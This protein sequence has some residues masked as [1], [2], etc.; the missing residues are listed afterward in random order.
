MAVGDYDPPRKVHHP[1]LA[2][3]GVGVQH[4]FPRKIE[5]GGS[6]GNLDN[7]RYL[8]SPR[9]PCL[10]IRLIRDQHGKIGL[11]EAA[12]PVGGPGFDWELDKTPGWIEEF[13]EN[14]EQEADRV[15]VRGVLSHF[16]EQ[17]SV[18]QLIALALEEAGL[19]QT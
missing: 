12:F 17:V 11:R 4:G 7:Q 18:D 3:A 8:V 10:V 13:R 5:G 14:G 16:V 19:C 6:V 1:I 9:M 15:S 2:D